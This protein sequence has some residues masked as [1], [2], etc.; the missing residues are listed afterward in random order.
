M[1][2]QKSYIL[3]IKQGGYFTVGERPYFRS[4]T[5][6]SD[7]FLTTNYFFVIL[8][9][10]KKDDRDG[11]AW[12][13]RLNCSLERRITTGSCVFTRIFRPS[14]LK[15]AWLFAPSYRTRCIPLGWSYSSQVWH[16]I[17]VK[18]CEV[19][20]FNDTIIW[21]ICKP[22]GRVFICRRKSQNNDER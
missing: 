7:P 6:K 14:Y 11:C 3:Q 10:R 13:V 4:S 17:D 21:R 16:M 2:G 22:F 20:V 8:Y 1:E 5:V 9:S 15:T 12:L 18:F 19:S